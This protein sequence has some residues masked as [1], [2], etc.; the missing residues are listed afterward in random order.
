MLTT[1]THARIGRPLRLLLFVL[2]TGSGLI[3]VFLALTAIPEAGRNPA[4]T[5]FGWLRSQWLAGF[6]V[7]MV[8]VGL[9]IAMATG[10]ARMLFV[11]LLLIICAASVVP[12]YQLWAYQVMPDFHRSAAPAPARRP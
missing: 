6:A 1:S 11:A 10:R 4:S 8:L 5:D 12:A 3:A 9:A 2:A 7:A